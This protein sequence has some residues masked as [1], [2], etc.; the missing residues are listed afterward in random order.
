MMPTDSLNPYRAPAVTAHAS[1]PST[2]RVHPLLFPVAAAACVVVSLALA[3]ALAGLFRAGFYLIV[4]IPIVAAAALGTSVYWAVRLGRCRNRWL[5][6]ALGLTCA[7]VVYF[8]YYYIDMVVS[9]GQ[10]AILRADFLPSY[11]AFRIENDVTLP[12]GAPDVNANAKPFWPLNALMFCLELG[13]IAWLAGVVGFRAASRAFDESQGRWAEA[14][15][16]TIGY[17]QSRIL[18]EAQQRGELLVGLSAVQPV[19]N[20]LQQPH[21]MLVLESFNSVD[22]LPA[23]SFL[24]AYELRMPGQV[25]TINELLY[26]KRLALRQ[27]ELSAAELEGAMRLFRVAA[28]GSF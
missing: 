15:H 16:T 13:V 25:L 4:L 9:V 27:V 14:V 18:K 26:S 17:G 10:Q 22:G 11:I 23:R 6:L 24:S 12:T 20:Q 3:A 7:L 19:R 2:G 5:G 28:S 1:P 8:G 21:C